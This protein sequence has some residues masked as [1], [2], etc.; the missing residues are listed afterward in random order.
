MNLKAFAM[1]GGAVAAGYV[2]GTRSGRARLEKFVSQ[3][4]DVLHDPR[5]QQNIA[6]VA[7]QVRS[8]AGR[9]P[10]PVSGIVRT[11]ADQVHQQFDHGPVKSSD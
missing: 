8:Q 5:T 7:E 4:N 3:A 1:M 6:D 9:L 2:L 11:A 10:D